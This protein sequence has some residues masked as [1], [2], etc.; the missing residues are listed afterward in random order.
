MSQGYVGCN[1]WHHNLN[2]FPHLGFSKEKKSI[3]H[4]DAGSAGL[5]VSH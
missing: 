2:D 4:L 3:S 5:S 1:T